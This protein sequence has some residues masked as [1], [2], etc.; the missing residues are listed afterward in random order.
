LKI[1]WQTGNL[2]LKT[3]VHPKEQCLVEVVY[4]GS[5]KI[6]TPISMAMPK[7]QDAANDSAEAP[8]ELQSVQAA[9]VKDTNTAQENLDF[10][11]VTD[12]A[13]GDFRGP[14]PPPA[15]AVEALERW[16]LPRKNRWRVFGTFM[17]RFGR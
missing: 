3:A 4:L 16:N 12:A 5:G 9:V 2:Q 7:S 13:N 1:P 8:M 10:P 15:T 14:I 11:A 6:E 17:S